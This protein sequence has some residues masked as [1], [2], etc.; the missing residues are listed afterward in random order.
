MHWKGT[1]VTAYGE[2]T[3]VLRDHRDLVMSV[4]TNGKETHGVI[5][6]WRNKSTAETEEK[7][8][9]VGVAQIEEYK[10]TLRNSKKYGAGVALTVGATAA[11]S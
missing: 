11:S 6:L 3:W 10:W 7:S 9:I 5:S 8:V 4:Q 1:G 2:A